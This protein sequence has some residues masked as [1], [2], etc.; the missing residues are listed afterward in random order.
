MQIE[1]KHSNNKNKAYVTVNLAYNG[2]LFL[3]YHAACGYLTSYIH[4]DE[5]RSWTEDGLKMPAYVKPLLKKA[6]KI[7]DSMGGN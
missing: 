3:Q 4:E 7:I 5:K 1:V 6:N 2:Y